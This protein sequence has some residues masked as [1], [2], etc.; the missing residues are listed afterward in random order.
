MQFRLDRHPCANLL[1]Q[2]LE[3]SIPKGGAQSALLMHGAAYFIGM[4]QPRPLHWSH[5]SSGHYQQQTY[6]DLSLLL[7][8]RVEKTL[9]M[10]VEFAYQ[11]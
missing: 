6:E 11:R 5:L 2:L 8:S 1:Y 10:L 9:G 7:Q 3:E 4:I